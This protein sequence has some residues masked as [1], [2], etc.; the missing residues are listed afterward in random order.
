MLKSW[1][2]RFQ[3]GLLVINGVVQPPING[4]ETLM[5]NRRE[6]TPGFRSFSGVIW[7]IPS[8][9][10]DFGAHLVVVS[11]FNFAGPI[12]RMDDIVSDVS[13]DCCCAGK[14]HNQVQRFIDYHRPLNCLHSSSLSYYSRTPGSSTSQ[15]GPSWRRPLCKELP[16]RA[17]PGR[18]GSLKLGWGSNLGW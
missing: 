18:K 7:V 10:L 6:I 4:Q 17:K 14:P 11:S 5:G 15:K 3:V 2:I 1:I 9:E 13:V 16:F 12:L 8:L